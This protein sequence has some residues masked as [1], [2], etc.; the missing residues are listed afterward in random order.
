MPVEPK[1]P[2]CNSLLEE[3]DAY[4]TE[5]NGSSIVVHV[6]GEC[7]LCEREYQWTEVY[8]YSHYEI[9]RASKK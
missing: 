5:M 9:L 8:N 1:C 4:D 7:P 2:I 3:I 6:V